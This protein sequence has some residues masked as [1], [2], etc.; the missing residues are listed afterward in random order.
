LN[1]GDDVKSIIKIDT[2]D[3]DKIDFVFP[4]HKEMISKA[5]LE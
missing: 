2:K 4:D 3:L 5:F 1:A